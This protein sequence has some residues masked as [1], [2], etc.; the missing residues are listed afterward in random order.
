VCEA[1][2]HTINCDG[3]S[4]FTRAECSRRSSAVSF[5][6][7]REVDPVQ[8]KKRRKQGKIWLFEKKISNIKSAEES[9][10]NEKLWSFHKY[11]CTEEGVK[12]YYRCN[13]VESVN[14]MFS[15]T[16]FIA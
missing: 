6:I 5:L 11:H 13:K 3:R 4:K 2:C 15:R 12:R 7:D 10:K 8:P 9:I 16:L 14:S 1:N